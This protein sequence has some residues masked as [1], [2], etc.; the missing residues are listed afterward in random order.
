MVVA[1]GLAQSQKRAIHPPK[2]TTVML[3]DPRLLVVD[4]EEVICEGCRRI[5]TRQGFEVEKCS[6]ANQGLSLAKQ[7]N[8]SAIL[9]D[10]KM[11]NMDGIAFLEALRKQKADVPVVLMTGYPSIPNAASAIRLGASDYVTKPFTPEEITQA[12]HRLLQHDA[13][14]SDRKPSATV[15]SAA[16]SE[17]FRFWRNAW[18]QLGDQRATRVGAVLTEATS[19]KIK[20][21]HLPRIGEVVYQGLPL[22]A[23]TVAGKPQQFVPAPLSGV[24]VAVNETLKAN[25]ALLMSDPCGRGWIACI[26]ATRVEDEAAACVSR[27]VILYNTDAG[28]GHVQAGKLSGLGCEVQQAS[29]WAHLSAG[30]NQAD[31]PVVILDG[32]TMGDNGPVT[33]GLINGACPGAKVIVISADANREAAYRLRRILYYAVEPFADNEMAQILEAAFRRPSSCTHSERHREIAQPL[34]SIAITNRNGTRVRLQIAPG[35]L[36]R[37]EGL[38]R[39]IHQKLVAKLFPMESS[40]EEISITP[41]NLVSIA[42]RC[43]RVIVLITGD[44]GRLPGSLLRDTK[45]EFV[46]L[47]GKGGDKVVALVVQPSGEA[48]SLRFDCETSDALA[49]HLVREMSSC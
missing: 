38:G 25:P 19:T 26:S 28:A 6:D 23:V 33:V 8:Y 34:N 22:A 7:N 21:F 40:P 48:N 42:Q 2:R 10:I 1:T 47:S 15:E 17:P 27:R 9:L 3:D 24:V 41:M 43:D 31:A 5:F 11:P 32:S 30:L 29:D 18:F 12:V 44:Q 49:T 4:D 36:R 16:P 45:G 37:E 20:S 39:L 14:P 35:L 46:S 13:V